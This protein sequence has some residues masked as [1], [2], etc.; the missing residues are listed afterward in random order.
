MEDSPP[1]KH[2]TVKPTFTSKDSATNTTVED[3]QTSTLDDMMSFMFDDENN[4]DMLRQLIENDL[5]LATMLYD[6]TNAFI[7]KKAEESELEEQLTS[8]N[9]NNNNGFCNIC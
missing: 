1:W 7:N 3:S 5:A 8:D 9:S 2:E 6:M 4:H